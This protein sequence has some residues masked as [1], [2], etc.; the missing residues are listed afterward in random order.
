[1]GGKRPDQYR[2]DADEAGATDYKFR[3][4]TANEAELSQEEAQQPLY[5]RIMKGEAQPGPEAR[6]SDDDEGA[7]DA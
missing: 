2:L 6:E 7:G 1:M 3:P 4:D 5:D